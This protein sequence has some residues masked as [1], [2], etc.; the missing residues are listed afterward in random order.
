ML[1]QKLQRQRQYIARRQEDIATYVGRNQKLIVL[2][3]PIDNVP[4]GYTQVTMSYKNEK[5]TFLIPQKAKLFMAN[6]GEN[7]KTLDALD[8]LADFYEE[9]GDFEHELMIGGSF[10]TPQ[11]NV[12]TLARNSYQTWT[13]NQLVR[14]KGGSEM[15]IWDEKE[16]ERLGVKDSYV[17]TRL[18]GIAAT[19]LGKNAAQLKSAGLEDI[20][21]HSTLTVRDEYENVT[22]VIRDEYETVT[23]LV[24]RTKIVNKT[25]GVRMSDREFAEIAC[26][27][28]SHY[29]LKKE[30]VRDSVKSRYVHGSRGWS[31]FS[32][33]PE[34]KIVSTGDHGHK[35]G[36][37]LANQQEMVDEPKMVTETVHHYETATERLHHHETVD[38]T[39]LPQIERMETEI[40][41]H[42]QKKGMEQTR[43]D[44]ALLRT[45][46]NLKYIAKEDPSKQLDVVS[47]AMEE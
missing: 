2:E 1:K 28:G 45:Y 4:D 13:I 30:F 12:S 17:D 15:P 29:I 39:A 26:W 10:N 14:Q 42:R 35:E 36:Y 32:N 34:H 27:D 33:G 11:V 41:E 21:E 38:Y 8:E 44:Q 46:L 31:E 3:A 20:L 37:K 24:N 16:L 9:C 6:P 7:G 22:K 40:K 18:K 23:R 47:K 5:H 25:G 43:H 19:M